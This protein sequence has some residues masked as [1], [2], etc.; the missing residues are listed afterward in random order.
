MPSAR[1]SDI[2]QQ[3]DKMRILGW[4]IMSTYP[5][6]WTD[7]PMD[8]QVSRGGRSCPEVR[9]GQWAELR[10]STA[11]WTGRRSQDPIHTRPAHRS[12][13]VDLNK[14]SSVSLRESHIQGPPCKFGQS[15]LPH[16]YLPLPILFDTPNDS[17]QNFCR[18]GGVG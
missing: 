8:R 13:P 11:S 5:D 3:D 10:A 18:E 6:G 16:P 14:A 7:G 15:I 9:L 17:A 4:S 1:M 12:H 2:L